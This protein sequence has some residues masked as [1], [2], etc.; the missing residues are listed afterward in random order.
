MSRPH[1]QITYPEKM[2]M[3]RHYSNLPNEEL[4]G[5]LG[6][7]YRTVKRWADELGLKKSDDYL[8]KWRK[9]GCFLMHSKLRRSKY[10]C[11][12][13]RRKYDWDTL[14]QIIAKRYPTEDNA[15]LCEEYGINRH[16]LVNRMNA[17]GI[18]KTKE[19]RN[20]CRLK[21]YRNALNNEKFN[22]KK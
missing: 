19:A 10:S 11:R 18:T 1:R 2:V 15:V 17:L 3:L 12:K 7:G 4:I 9:M 14:D 5:M 8:D 21:G 6:V 20:E 13:K 22:R 16:T